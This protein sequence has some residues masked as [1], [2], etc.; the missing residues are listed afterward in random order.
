MNRIKSILKD[1]TSALTSLD[2]GED[3]KELAEIAS[4]RARLT[5]G[6]RRYEEGMRSRDTNGR[7]ILAQRFLKFSNSIREE[8]EQ[9]QDQY[10]KSL[11]KVFDPIITRFDQALLGAIRDGDIK[12][13]KAILQQ[14]QESGIIQSSKLL[15][16][17]TY[18]DSDRK[19]REEGLIDK[20]LVH[21]HFKEVL[22]VTQDI[23][24]DL[25]SDVFWLN[26]FSFIGPQGEETGR[27]QWTYSLDQM[28]EFL[29]V[30]KN[31]AP[32]SFEAVVYGYRG[33]VNRIENGA[34]LEDQ[35]GQTLDVLTMLLALDKEHFLDNLSVDLRNRVQL[36]AQ[37]MP[38]KP[39]A[40]PQL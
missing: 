21:G 31:E 27:V 1:W 4:L 25:F 39:A 14:G 22:K 29:S 33:I 19:P 30:L 3:N 26:K 5:R 37:A 16:F 10:T 12:G 24:P 34:I 8:I 9:H 23:V 6:Q 28:Q 17:H 18:A 13:Y 40:G 36:R 20:A 32:Q 11:A 15:Y 7:K 35:E 2:T 38:A